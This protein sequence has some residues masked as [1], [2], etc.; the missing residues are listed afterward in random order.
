MG[1]GG[2]SRGVCSVLQLQPFVSAFVVDIVHG[3]FSVV[4]SN[5]ALS[6]KCRSPSGLRSAVPAPCSVVPAPWSVVCAPWSLR[7]PRAARRWS[8]VDGRCSMVDG[9]CSSG[10]PP[11]CNRSMRSVT[12]G[13]R[14]QT[15]PGRRAA[16]L[17][18]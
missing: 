16:G 14:R 7:R 13:G 5:C 9:L 10:A 18:L 3:P 8:M 17:E 12:A 1:V 6:V 15:S 4:S 11:T 2:G